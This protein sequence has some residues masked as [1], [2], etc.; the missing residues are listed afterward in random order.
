MSQK[1]LSNAVLEKLE[2]QTQKFSGSKAEISLLSLEDKLEKLG[3]YDDSYKSLNQEYA[4]EANA[5]SSTFKPLLAEGAT[6]SAEFKKYLPLTS[7]DWNLWLETFSWAHDDEWAWMGICNGWSPAA[8]REQKPLQ[9]VMAIRGE[10][11]VL[12][13]EGDI[14]GLLSWVWGWQFPAQTLGAG[15][16]CDAAES[17]TIVKNKRIIDGRLCEGKGSRPGRC[18]AANTIYI[19]SDDAF[20]SVPGRKVKFGFDP[21]NNTTHEASLKAVLGN[22]YY[23]AEVK[24]LSSG[25]K[26]KLLIVLSDGQPAAHRGSGIHGFTKKVVKEIEKEGVVDIYG[27]GIISSAVKQFYKNHTVISDSSELEKALLGV[28]KQKLFS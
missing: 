16:R 21:G 11:K 22:S 6:L 19:S 2:Q 7:H 4:R 23:E 17:K 14:R 10:K 28:L 1:S 26:R 3:E 18:V 13:T 9:S 12:L 25:E 27:L 20:S 8:L 5:A 24:D 15:V